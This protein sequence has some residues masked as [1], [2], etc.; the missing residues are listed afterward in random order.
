MKNRKLKLSRR[1]RLVIIGAALLVLLAVAYA[2]HLA[3]SK[4]AHKGSGRTPHNPSS[5]SSTTSAV[6]K[7]SANGE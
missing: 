1:E 5:S 6:I 4:P 2:L 3:L 7:R